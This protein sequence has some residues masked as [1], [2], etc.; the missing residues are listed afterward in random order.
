MLESIRGIRGGLLLQR[1]G[2]VSDD[3]DGR[4]SRLI[5]YRVD[6]ESLAIALKGMSSGF[7]EAHLRQTAQP[8]PYGRQFN[9]S[10]TVFGAAHR[11]LGF[12]E[13]VQ[14]QHTAWGAL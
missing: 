6:Q 11:L 9:G 13:R 8:L 10:L 14:I 4:R 3:G 12:N 2:P 5:D 1:P 7:P